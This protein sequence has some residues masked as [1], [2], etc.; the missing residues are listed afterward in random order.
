MIDFHF[1]AST[2]VVF[3]GVYT[4]SGSCLNFLVNPSIFGQWLSN[5]L[6]L[7]KKSL[8]KFVNLQLNGL[9]KHWF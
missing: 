6:V 4:F 9:L 2:F 3:S 5:W 7:S 1:F 8:V